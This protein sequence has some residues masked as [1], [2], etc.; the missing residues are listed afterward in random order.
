MQLG[1]GLHAGKAVQG[2]I[3]TQRKLDATY[4]SEAVEF[5]E[6]L[7]SNTKRYGVKVLMSDSFYKELNTANRRRCRKVDQIKVDNANDDEDKALLSLYTFDMDIDAKF[8]P[9]ETGD[10]HGD[11]FF[12]QGS[13]IQ[14]SVRRLSDK[15]S[16]MNM[17]SF[18]KTGSDVMNLRRSSFGLPIQR[19]MSNVSAEE[20]AM[21]L[22]LSSKSS[23]RRSSLN[24]A[25]VEKQANK[26]KSTEEQ[27]E[28]DSNLIPDLVL[29]TGPAIYNESVWVTETMQMIRHRAN[30]GLFMQNFNSGL[31]NYYARDWAEARRLFKGILDRFEDGPSR[32]FL[33]EIEKHGAV[34]PADFKD[35]NEL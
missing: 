10:K 11:T 24:N 12:V 21:D 16:S 2:A 17:R 33:K 30:D 4:L 26:K 19:M 13:N 18:I 5:A 29:P 35:Y 22:D 20:E 6:S 31:R 34:P 27:T 1:F 32:M 7:E 14:S 28:F 8:A 15:R 3:G 23:S 25:N 9:H